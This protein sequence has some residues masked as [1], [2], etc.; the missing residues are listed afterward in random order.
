MAGPPFRVFYSYSHADVRML[1]KLR[2]HMTMLRREGLITEWSDREIEA[3]SE[4]R[5]EIERELESADV[6]LL[7][8]SSDFLASDFCYEE[9]MTR[10]IERARAGEVLVIGVMLRPV[11]GWH[12][13]P[14]A[15]FQL[16]PRNARPITKW[17]D[18][19]SAYADV[20]ESIRATLETRAQSTRAGPDGGGDFSVGE[21]R[22]KGARLSRHAA[23]AEGLNADQLATLAKL[24][25]PATPDQEVLSESELA[26]LA[27]ISDPQQRRNQ[28]DE[29]VSQKSNTLRIMFG[30]LNKMREDMLRHVADAEVTDPT[31]SP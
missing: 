27:Q 3:G 23:E 24:A 7:L 12:N 19:D 17:S 11:D 20:A 26:L 10:A 31:D 15:E 29:M 5:E 2:K 8:V 21:V 13:T 18:M 22:R 6:I 30:Q 14:F 4:W 16:V 1:D 28:R 25:D 9:E